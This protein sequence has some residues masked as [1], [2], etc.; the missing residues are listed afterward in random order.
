MMLS[1]VVKEQEAM[2]TSLDS[3]KKITK[4][5]SEKPPASIRKSSERFW[6][7]I[8]KKE[9]DVENKRLEIENKERECRN[10]IAE[11]QDT[12]VTMD[13]SRK[14]LDDI[15]ISLDELKVVLNRATVGSLE[16]L[17]RSFVESKNIKTSDPMMKEILNQRYTEPMG[18]TK[19]RK[20]LKMK[21]KMKTKMKK[22]VKRRR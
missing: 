3:V 20:M 5:L 9:G 16:G 19:R 15:N 6:N 11:L 22:T 2:L 18:G 21:M 7:I 8:A 12:I 10:K 4:E 14:I 1:D 13:K 17:T